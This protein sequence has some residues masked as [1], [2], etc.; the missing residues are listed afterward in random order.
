MT[1]LTTVLGML[2]LAL[3]IGACAETQAPLATV[4]I[5]GLTV[6]TLLTLVVVPVIYSVLDDIGERA[7]TGRLSRYLQKADSI[8][9]IPYLQIIKTMI[10]NHPYVELIIPVETSGIFFR[11]FLY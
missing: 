7:K 1:T 2:P 11:Q 6:S 9:A 5:G 4:V 10:G 3:G 8:K